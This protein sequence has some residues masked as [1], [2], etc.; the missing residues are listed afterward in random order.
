MTQAMYALLSQMDG[1]IKDP[2]VLGFEPTFKRIERQVNQPRNDSFP[3][4]NIVY[5]KDKESFKVEMALAGYA[6]DDFSI[7]LQ[8]QV[9]TIETYEELEQPDETYVHQGIARRKFRKQFTLGEYLVVEGAAFVNGMLTITINKELPEEK[10]PKTIKINS[11]KS[12][13]KSLLTE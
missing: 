5:S 13:K 8:D 12:K 10:K 7:T 3:P 11:K 1:M 4:H 6:E 2:R 9:L